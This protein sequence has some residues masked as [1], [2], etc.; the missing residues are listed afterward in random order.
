M[1]SQETGIFGNGQQRC[2]IR[3][4][5]RLSQEEQAG[6]AGA[7]GGKQLLE[8]LAAS[9]WSREGE[10]AHV[11]HAVS[12]TKLIDYVRVSLVAL[13]FPSQNKLLVLLCG[14]LPAAPSHRQF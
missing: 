7:I 6:A 10:A 12:S 3:G 11:E 9:D 5:V 13:L 8:W 2:L 1:R 4:L 14:H